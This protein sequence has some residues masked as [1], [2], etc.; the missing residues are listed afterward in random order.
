M[1]KGT[2]CIISIAKFHSL[3]GVEYIEQKN[4]ENTPENMWK[5]AVVSSSQH[6]FI[7]L[8]CVCHRVNSCFEWR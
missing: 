7:H 4:G 3:S 2:T 8:L 1:E 6:A 5:R